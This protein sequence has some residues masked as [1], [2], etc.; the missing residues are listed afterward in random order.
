MIRF[1]CC[2]CGQRISAE[3][4][5]ANLEG[6]CPRCQGTFVVPGQAIMEGAAA[7]SPAMSEQAAA[8][9]QPEALP[10]VPSAFAPS[11]PTLHASP[12]AAAAFA[13]PPEPPVNRLPPASRRMEPRQARSLRRWV[14]A[15]TIAAAVLILLFV[16]IDERPA[17]TGGM[18]PG[19]LA[20]RALGMLMAA[21]LIA[22]GV[23]LVVAGIAKACG[24][25]FARVWGIGY[26]AAVVMVTLLS[27]L[28]QMG[29]GTMMHRRPRPSSVQLA[30]MHD[31]V[32]GMETDIR[33]MF[34]S[35]TG[36]DGLPTPVKVE[37]KPARPPSNDIERLRQIQQGLMNEM[38][39]LQNEYLGALETAGLSRLLDPS[40]VHADEGFAESRKILNE[41]GRTVLAYRK[42][43]IGLV[44]GSSSRFQGVRFD[45]ISERD[46]VKGFEDGLTKSL[47][48]L[49]ENWELELAIID[50]YTE[51]IDHLEE[52]RA[53]WG[54]ESGQF[55]FLQT[56][57]LNRFNEI[58]G[59]V[60]EVSKRQTQIRS[61]AME[62]A[63]SKFE[64][65]KV[66]MPK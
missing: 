42:R 5:Y 8:F 61:G 35:A 36:P 54:V 2:H 50:H 38:A 18:D 32:R 30:G 11:P 47:P 65:L 10:P 3:D 45:Y 58:M 19:T 20:A 60:D 40:R 53:R 59:K 51:I 48:L 14:V 7:I 15:T 4:E 12:Q 52:T 55:A 44:R 33:T 46:A 26:S 21:V 16:V 24:A 63:L 31:S 6:E 1:Y 17:F 37:L 57:D 25:N 23:T 13:Q 56:E 49:E 29:S 39:E 28:G 66:Q 34:E 27:L 9:E 22:A 62:S 64:K 43:S 41:L